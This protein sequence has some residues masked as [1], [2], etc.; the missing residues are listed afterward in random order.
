MDFFPSLA[1]TTTFAELVL[2]AFMTSL[3]PKTNLS[4]IHG[5]SNVVV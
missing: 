2:T 5:K 1:T 3:W 4:R